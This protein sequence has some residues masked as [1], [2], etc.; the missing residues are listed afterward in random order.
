MKRTIVVT[1]NVGKIRIIK[2]PSGQAPLEVRKAWLGLELEV[3]K[4]IF[5]GEQHGVLG[6]QSNGPAGYP[7]ES[8]YAI[9]TLRQKNP[10]AA[11]WWDDNF[12]P[13]ESQWLLFRESDC[14]LVN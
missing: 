9:E 6:G 11:K 10:V 2:V 5:I 3:A 14:E 12:D 7:V 8:V 13:A 4:G 1:P